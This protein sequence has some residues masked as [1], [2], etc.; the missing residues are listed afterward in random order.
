MHFLLFIAALYFLPTIVAS[1]RH[2][3]NSGL[4]F[5]INLFAGWT[6]IGWIAAFIMALV[7]SP[8][9]MYVY[10]ATQEYRRY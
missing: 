10:P 6:V 2:T 9:V 5:L 3:H 8:R 7:S 4:I 1:L